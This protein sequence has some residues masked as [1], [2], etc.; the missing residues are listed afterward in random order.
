MLSKYK[1]IQFLKFHRNMFKDAN[2]KIGGFYKVKLMDKIQTSE[3]TE[4]E[5]IEPVYHELMLIDGKVELSYESLSFLFSLDGHDK[6]LLLFLLAYCIESDCTFVWNK[7]VALHYAD[8]Y[9]TMTDKKTSD[10]VIRQSVYALSKNNIIKKIGSGKYMLNPLLYPISRNNQYHKKELI[11][12]YGNLN[13]NN[14][15]GT[16]DSLFCGK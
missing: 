12:T 15:K 6:N 9:N 11:K 16:I 5:I 10:D 2:R 3:L 1:Y 8:A 4:G 14:S 7:I 13:A